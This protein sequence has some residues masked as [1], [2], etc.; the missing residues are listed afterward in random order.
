MHTVRTSGQSYI[1]AIV[2]DDSRARSVN[3]RHAPLD[4]AAQLE[5]IAFQLS[6]LHQIDAR[7]RGFANLSDN[8]IV[9][10]SRIVGR[11]GCQPFAM[12]DQADDGP[13][14]EGSNHVTHPNH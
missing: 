9:N 4:Q 3:R 13:R 10:T 2:H 7:R 14:I 8:R 12:C 11:A 6:Y 1:E 5:S